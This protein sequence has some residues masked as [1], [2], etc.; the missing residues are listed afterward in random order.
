MSVNK[1]EGRIGATF[2][3]KYG[4]EAVVVDYVGATEVY[5][6]FS[7]YPWEHKVEWSDL[8]KGHFK[9]VMKPLISGVGFVGGTE[10]KT[11][12]EGCHTQAYR[13]WGNM[14]K[15]C[16]DKQDKNYGR[17]GG[18]GVFVEDFWHNFQNFAEWYYTEAGSR[19][20]EVLQLD[21]D[22]LSPHG[23]I[24]YSR[25]TCCLV[26]AALNGAI[27]DC[28]S[29]STTNI[30]GI[31]KLPSGKWNVRITD[32]DREFKGFGTFKN[33]NTAK[34]VWVNNKYEIVKKLCQN[35][36]KE[37]LIKDKELNVLSN[38][39]WFYRRFFNISGNLCPD[40]MEN[41]L[42]YSTKVNEKIIYSLEEL[43]YEAT[44]K[45]SLIKIMDKIKEDLERIIDIQAD[46]IFNSNKPVEGE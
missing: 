30:K 15:R 46:L 8:K 10:Y 5:I 28:K 20:I 3:N 16:Y 4:D 45:D 11:K 13:S 18:S 39:E 17:Y 32:I 38:K 29:C 9:N 12:I 34:M 25:G 36:Y 40:E 24:F 26:P 44:S 27:T 23:E 1:R 31:R 14:I 21:K 41:Y 33:L 6:M 43:D 42:S 19:P 2:K 35:L 37:G 7:E 22:I